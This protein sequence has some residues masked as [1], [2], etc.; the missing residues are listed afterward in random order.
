MSFRKPAE[1]LL[2]KA[3]PTTLPHSIRRYPS[4]ILSLEIVKLIVGFVDKKG[5][6]LEFLTAALL[7]EMGGAILA[8]LIVENH[9]G[10]VLGEEIREGE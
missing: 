1:C 5:L 6:K 3:L 4:F 2:A 10:I 8:N 7:G 9:W